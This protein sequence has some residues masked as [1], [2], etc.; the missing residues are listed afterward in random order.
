MNPSGPPAARTLAR[1]LPPLLASLLFALLSLAILPYPGL[2]HDEVLF[3]V[4][5]YLPEGT[6]YRIRL[7]GTR[8]PLML[9]GYLGALKTWL[10]A[11]I[12]AVVAP[13]R[14]SVRVPVVIVGVLT[15][16]V[17]WNWVRRVAGARAAAFSVALLATHAAFVV[18][19][20]F[21]WGP[22]AIQHLCLMA[23][24]LFIQ[25]WLET[26]TNS[27]PS[28]KPNPSYLL[29]AGA[30]LWGLGLWDKALM[31]W[32][33][34]GLA[35]AA[36]LVYPAQL[37]R[38]L[39][40]LPF[41]IAAVAILLGALPLVL[42][43]V[44]SRGETAS[45]NTKLSLREIPKKVSELK[46]TL[47]G[48]VLLGAIA[49]TTPGLIVQTP[50]SAAVR[51]SLAIRNISGAFG[52]N[53]MLPAIFFSLLYTAFAWTTPHGRLLRF[54][55]IAAVVT[56]LQMAANTGTGGGAHHVILLWPLP[57]IFVG[58]AL[59]DLTERLPGYASPAV[60]VAALA[61]V[62][63]NV[64]NCNEY[65]A[66]L[67]LNGAVGG[68]SDA[69]YRLTGA[70]VPY[71]AQKIGIVDWGYLNTLRMMYEGELR[72]TVVS[73]ALHKPV[74]TEQENRQLTEMIQSPDYVFIRHTDDKQIFPDVNAKLRA[75]ETA[76]GYSESVERVVHDNQGRPVFEIYRLLPNPR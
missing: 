43:N 2:Q 58:V 63:V 13:S 38:Q 9:I 18:T 15:I 59:A 41:A 10:Y 40:R 34:I 6:L 14:W 55:L 52:G 65:L 4:P 68:W 27:T 19:N 56:W 36:V 75:A 69:S 67:A 70:M 22:V 54:I 11:A 31:L 39:R 20:T 1:W 12:F 44:A 74:M 53:W 71:R 25:I 46:D 26:E 47:D 60:T 37:F 48:S 51:A 5:L 66:N 57:C 8:I 17:T 45:A 29:A 61:L 28:R 24:L 35:V 3:T 76:L 49:A 21:D 73:D 33:L 30:F 23:G 7:F 50:Q 62:C 16:L 42:Y 32:P 72:M 64:L